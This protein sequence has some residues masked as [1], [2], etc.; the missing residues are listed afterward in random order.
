MLI[1]K[2]IINYL[3]YTL[4]NT[5]HTPHTIPNE[6]T[7]LNIKVHDAIRAQSAIGWQNFLKGRISTHWA[8]AQA[9]YYTQRTD[10]DKRK[11]PILR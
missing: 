2:A 6:I 5:P 3:I 9:M 10:I 8:E 1:Y 4:S 11:Y 7:L